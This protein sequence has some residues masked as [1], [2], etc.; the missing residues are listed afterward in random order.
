[1][2]NTITLVG[3]LGGDPETFY[4]SD[5][6]PIAKFNLAFNSSPKKTCWV[7]VVAFGKLAESTEKY[8]KKGNRIGIIGTLDQDSWE[9]D[10]QKR[11]VHQL[12]ARSYEFIKVDF[13]D[14]DATPF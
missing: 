4:T 14:G 12:I 10:G 11:S 8:L 9:K 3:N 5:G 6:D 13:E 1:M 2:L 7:K